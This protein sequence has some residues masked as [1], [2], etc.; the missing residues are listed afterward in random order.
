MSSLRVSFSPSS[1]P[2]ALAKP[3]IGAGSP[4]VAR[5]IPPNSLSAPLVPS[6]LC[7]VSF[8]SFPTA[9]AN[10]STGTCSSGSARWIPPASSSRPA[11]V[12]SVHLAPQDD[13]PRPASPPRLRSILKTRPAVPVSPESTSDALISAKPR[14]T[15]TWRTCLTRTK[16][17][18]NRYQK[19]I[20][21]YREVLEMRRSR[22]AATLFGYSRTQANRPPSVTIRSLASAK[23]ELFGP[24]KCLNNS[25]EF[26]K[27]R[28]VTARLQPEV[29]YRYLPVPSPSLTAWA[30]STVT[31][32]F[33]AIC[34]KVVEFL[35]L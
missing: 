18:P 28:P 22:H 19:D 12:K 17:I 31:G 21:S 15:V 27:H 32:W 1:S 6:P 35:G 30:R 26:S 29:V 24:A 33:D 7:H 5:W 23:D 4:G 14:K 25:L 16:I 10:P 20:K 3:T 11:V 2:T 8:S 13:R 9:L 34:T